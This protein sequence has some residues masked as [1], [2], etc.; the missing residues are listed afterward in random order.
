MRRGFAGSDFV[1]GATT[2]GT[3]ME[4][5]MADGASLSRKDVILGLQAFIRVLESGA[6]YTTFPA[7]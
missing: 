2:G 5:R 3:D 1:F 4:L 6:T 7:S